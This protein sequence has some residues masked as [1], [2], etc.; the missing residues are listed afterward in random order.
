MAAGT[1]AVQP[2]L[3]IRQLGWRRLP[4]RLPRVHLRACAAARPAASGAYQPAARPHLDAR[5]RLCHYPGNVVQ[6]LACK[7]RREGCE[8]WAR[9]AQG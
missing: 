7:R 4:A 3:G 1:S 6:L 2:R 8:V 5:H 9:R